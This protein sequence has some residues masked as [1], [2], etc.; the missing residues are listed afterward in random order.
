VEYLSKSV[1][2]FFSGDN[3]LCPENSWLT[4]KTQYYGKETVFIAAF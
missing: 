3:D 4:L 1:I 2:N